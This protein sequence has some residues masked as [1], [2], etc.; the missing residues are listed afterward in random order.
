SELIY[1]DTED[2]PV[3]TDPRAAAGKDAPL[4]WPERGTNI[5]FEAE[6]GD[7]AA[8]DEAFARAD[9]IVKLD[10]I[11][12]RTVTNFMEPRGAI[13]EYDPESGRYTLTVSSQ[14]VHLIQPILANNIFGIDKDRI[15]VVT[16][17]VGGGFGTKY[18]T[19]REY[20]LVLLAAERIGRPV[21]W[22]ADRLE[23]FI[24]DYHGR[25]H[26]SHAELAL[27]KDLNFIGLKVD[28]LANIG[29]FLSQMS[30]F[31]V[32]NGV[33]MTPG[34]YRT[35]VAYARVRG[36]YTNSV[37]VDA[38]RGA[39]RPEAA[40]LIERLVDKAARELN[41][42]PEDLR[43]RNFV[44]PQEMPFTSP[45]VRTCDTGEFNQHMTRAMEMADWAGFEKR[46]ARDEQDGLLRGIG[47]ATYIEACAGGGSEHATVSV[48]PDGTAEV[49][50]GSQ[51]SG[52]GHET[53][54]A[55]LASEHLGIG[56][57]NITV[58]QG[59]TDKVLRGTGTGGSRSIPVGGSSVALASERL[60]TRI[61]E[62]ASSELEANVDDLELVGGLVRIRGT[63]RSISFGS[64]V[65]EL[66]EN[67]RT[68]LEDWQPP[69]ATFPN[70]TH[71]AEVVIDPE[72]GAILTEKYIVV[73][74][75]GVTLNPILLD[76]QIHG[77]V[78]QGI[79]QAVMEH[80][81]YD[82]DSGQ[83][84]TA[85]F[86]DYCLPRARD[87]PMFEIDTRNVPSTTN[88]LGMKGAGE[89]GAIGSCPAMVNAVV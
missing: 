27:D 13:G 53:A 8:T 36:V 66:P 40:Y 7:K 51:S 69:N 70:G 73:D 64:A 50:V 45:T 59:D 63:D 1:L 57:E 88:A 37:P 77:G 83:L 16:P 62:V 42:T 58:I 49:L 61:K 39:G 38:Y 76:G 23:H 29:A 10:L 82:L 56:L 85:S 43:R 80:T 30:N 20:A 71:I 72:T 5:A 78:V 60:A 87:V 18:F 35:P 2:L 79:G 74:D 67:Q 12:N 11:N 19:Y 55:Q 89:A 75:F 84:L 44:S 28:T 25:D 41:V 34:C 6:H 54:Y 21:R 52:Q 65:A 47:M 9:H 86:M 14:G 22:I 46:R 33:A 17:D 4:L 48:R 81:I 68:D 31:I 32:V 26:V 3:V 15:H 24:A